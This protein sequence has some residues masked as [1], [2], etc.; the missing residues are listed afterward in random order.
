MRQTTICSAVLLK[1]L[2]Y[3]MGMERY[4]H[5]LDY[6]Q[7]DILYINSFSKFQLLEK[8][9]KNNFAIY[10]FPPNMRRK[11]KIYHLKY[12]C[13]KDKIKYKTSLHL[14]NSFEDNRGISL[15]KECITLFIVFTVYIL[16]HGTGSLQCMARKFLFIFNEQPVCAEIHS[17][18]Y[19]SARKPLYFLFPSILSMSIFTCIAQQ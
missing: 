10:F 18:I 14:T 1:Y 7:V 13:L 2:V 6:K 19:F 17:K 11:Q 5:N 16:K 3:D 4:S 8:K 9:K 15:L 12:L